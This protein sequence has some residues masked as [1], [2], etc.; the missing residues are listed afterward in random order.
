MS[1][2][3]LRWCPLR[4]SR[5]SWPRWSNTRSGHASTIGVRGRRPPGTPRPQPIR[6]SA[7]LELVR[8]IEFALKPHQKL[9]EREGPAL[10]EAL[11]SGDNDDR[12]D[13]QVGGLLR[14]MVER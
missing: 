11:R 7:V 1:P 9:L 14:A 3:T 6:A 2:S 8:L 12:D 10:W 13:G 5:R 4:S